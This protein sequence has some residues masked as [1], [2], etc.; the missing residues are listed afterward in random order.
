MLRWCLIP[1]LLFV[2]YNASAYTVY[3]TVTNT[4]TNQPLENARVEIHSHRKL[5]RTATT[6]SNGVIRFEKIH[7]PTIYVHVIDDSGRFEPYH[8]YHSHFG[9]KM[10]RLKA[11]LAPSNSYETEITRLEDS[12]YGTWT[13]ACALQF[14]EQDDQSYSGSSSNKEAQFPGGYG[15]LTN[16]LDRESRLPKDSWEKKEDQGRVNF[17]VEKDGSIS[18]VHVVDTSNPEIERELKRLFWAMPDWNPKKVNK[19]PVRSVRSVSITF[20]LVGL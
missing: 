12:L 6:D 8:H 11:E 9:A 7:R 18:H 14:K 3:V 16:Y 15:E 13:D 17:V 19:Q 10:F 2:S 5:I 4:H 1:I 20:I